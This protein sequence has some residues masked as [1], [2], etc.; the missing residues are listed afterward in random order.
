MLIFKVIASA[1]VRVIVSS[2]FSSSF[3]SSSRWF[4]VWNF[5]FYSG[6]NNFVHYH[7]IC[8]IYIELPHLCFLMGQCSCVRIPVRNNEICW[9]VSIPLILIFW[10]FAGSIGLKYILSYF[11]RISR[12]ERKILIIVWGVSISGS[13]GQNACQ[14][15]QYELQI[16]QR[17]KSY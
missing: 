8:V 12:Y 15:H 9:P 6:D 16:N 14:I 7:W 13:S 11:V 10:S 1:E 2:R 17:S 5:N 4:S 3:S